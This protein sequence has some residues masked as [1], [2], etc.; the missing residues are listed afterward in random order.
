MVTGKPAYV[1]FFI[2]YSG[3]MHSFIFT[4]FVD[5]SKVIYKKTYNG[6]LVSNLLGKTLSTKD[7]A[8]DVRLES[9]G[10]VTKGKLYLLEMIDFDSI[11]GMDWLGNNHVTIQSHKKE[12]V[13]QLGEYEVCFFRARFR[14]FPHLV[15][16]LQAK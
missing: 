7:I 2:F 10:K 9:N 14:L 12:I 8:K 6:L 15:S 11:L 13:I 1:L 5:K 4:Y 16:I 3:A